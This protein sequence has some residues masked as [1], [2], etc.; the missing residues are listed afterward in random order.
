VKIGKPGTPA[1]A[2]ARERLLYF[3]RFFTYPVV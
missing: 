1:A 2:N 3:L